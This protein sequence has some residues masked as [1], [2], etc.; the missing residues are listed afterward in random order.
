MK[1]S[2]WHVW[3]MP[4]ILGILSLF[5]LVSALIGDG[6]MDFLSWLTLGIPLIVIGWFIRRPRA[7]QKH[8]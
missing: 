4:L 3:S 1:S 6:L 5:G 2:F 8:R 7:N